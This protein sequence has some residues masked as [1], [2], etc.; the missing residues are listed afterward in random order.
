M[1]ELGLFMYFG[2]YYMHGQNIFDFNEDITEE[3][4]N[5]DVDEVPLSSIKL[6]YKAFY[7]C[8]GPQEKLVLKKGYFIDGAYIHEMKP[9]SFDIF[10]TSV[11]QNFNYTKKSN[12]VLDRDYS[13]H[14]E[15][16]TEKEQNLTVKSG[17]DNYIKENKPFDKLEITPKT[18]FIDTGDRKIM[19]VDK[20]GYSQN[21]IA[22][23]MIQSYEIFKESLKLIFNAL[24]YITTYQKDVVTKY[25][26]DSPATLVNKFEHSKKMKDVR[27][28]ESKL[29]SMGY[30]K[31]HFCDTIIKYPNQVNND[32]GR[33]VSTHWRRG[34]W[35]HQ[36]YGTGFSEHKLIWIRPTIVRKDKGEPIKGHIYQVELDK[37]KTI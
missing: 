12:F 6:P 3:F 31:I 24:C 23:E 4:L 35:R 25:P 11:R 29:A 20:I 7:L 36:A 8:F 22:D 28:N 16:D 32:T 14:W 34:H 17:I 26:D 5:T 33:E 19:L 2:A 18:E 21:L 37:D 10:L 1:E 27:R 15:F 13:Y 30:T 9:F